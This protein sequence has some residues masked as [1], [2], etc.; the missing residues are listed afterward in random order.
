MKTR[1]LGT[2]LAAL[3]LEWVTPRGQKG[4]NHDVTISKQKKGYGFTF[5]ND[6]VKKMSPNGIVER[7]EFAIV[8]EDTIIFCPSKHGYALSIPRH[9]DEDGNIKGTSNPS[10]TYAKSNTGS[11]QK[12]VDVLENLVGD[13]ELKYERHFKL[14]Y[15]SKEE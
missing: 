1:D 8:N 4:K 5:R 15:I 3:N 9:K 6:C 12:I 10:F 11:D 2:K 7:V 14:Y 13:Y